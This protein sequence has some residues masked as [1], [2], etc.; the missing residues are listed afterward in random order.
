[1]LEGSLARQPVKANQVNHRRW[2]EYTLIWSCYTEPAV[3][4]VGADKAL[5]DEVDTPLE[6]GPPVV[7][8]HQL[9]QLARQQN[10]H[11]RSSQEAILARYGMVSG[12]VC[13]RIESI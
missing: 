1:M 11:Q 6:M 4:A 2:N 10:G 7:V 8:H 9:G 5:L 13:L 12:F 3:K